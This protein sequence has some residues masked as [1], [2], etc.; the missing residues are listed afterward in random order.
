MI[1]TLRE[2]IT[3]TGGQLFAGSAGGGVNGA[4]IDSREAQAGELFFPLQGEKD[5]GHRYIADALARGAAA[6]LLEKGCLHLFDSAACPQGK[7]LIAVEDC[8][9]SLQR[10]AAYYRGKFSLPVVAVTG[11]NGK[12]TT[13]DFIASV[14]RTRYEVLKT[15]GNFNNEIGLPLTLL[16]LGPQHEIAVLELGMRG[17]GQ[18]ALLSSLCKPC[19]GI[20]TNIGEAHLELLGSRENIS[21][22]KGELLEAMGAGG[23]AFLN[24]DDPYLRRMGALFAGNVLYFGFDEASDLRV[25]HSYPDNG[26]CSFTAALPKG[27]TETYWIPLPGKHNVYNALAAV[28]LGLHYSMSPAE[29]R[30][31][32][33]SAT[34]SAMRAERIKTKSGF[35]IINDAYNASPT[36]MRYA[37]QTLREGAGSALTVAVLG[38][39]FEL[40]SY[41]EEGH[42]R[43]GQWVADAGIDYL[44]TVGK[45]SFLIGEGAVD[46]GMSPGRVWHCSEHADALDV[47]H[48][49][50]LGGSHILIK[51]SRRMSMER[52]ADGLL[53]A[54]NRSVNT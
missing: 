22:A 16:R 50:P 34:F 48:S 15:E 47:L 10:I 17:P 8:L 11:S 39:M 32:L 5:N 53:Q 42:R 24:G 2:I 31:G 6:S 27:D 45:Q 29:I 7:A 23:T 41:T 13:K 20:I 38:D 52:I 9:Q 54:Y 25:C 37:L 44:V 1:L 40:G 12:T 18:I 43:T 4:I 19:A 46:A 3:V 36:S 51:G 35:W 21:R 33:A 49:L 14:F 30:K 26:G 28:A